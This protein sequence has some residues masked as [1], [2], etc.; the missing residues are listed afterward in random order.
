MPFWKKFVSRKTRLKFRAGVLIAQVAVWETPD[1][2]QEKRKMKQK[3]NLSRMKPFA[4]YSRKFKLNFKRK[5]P[6]FWKIYTG[7][8]P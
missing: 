2:L 1:T 3:K 5:K 6:I 8:A 7:G 4:L